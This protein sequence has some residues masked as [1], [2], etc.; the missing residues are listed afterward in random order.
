MTT[1]LLFSVFPYA[2]LAVLAGGL[3][4]RCTS[5][6]SRGVDVEAAEAWTLF[7][8]GRI[9][10]VGFLVLALL[11]LGG[12]MLPRAILSWNTVPL[13]LYVLEGSGFAFGLLALGWWMGVMRRHLRSSKAVVSDFADG[14]FLS[15]TFVGIMSGL[16]TASLYRWGS[17]WGAATL[18]PY[19]SSLLAGA[20]LVS[21]VEQ[22]PLLVQLHVVAAFAL[23]M[24]FPFTRA[25]SLVK[26]AVL[27]VVSLLEA[28]FSAASGGAR[29]WVDRYDPASW[30]WPEEGALDI[31]AP[32]AG[33]H[34][35][36]GDMVVRG[37]RSPATL[38]PQS[39]VRPS[40]V[41]DIGSGYS[42]EEAD[43]E[44]QKTGSDMG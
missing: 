19:G 12:M 10:R 1:D 37:P 6:S 35:V 3:V 44:T 38:P 42:L 14:A 8:G 27:R 43:A 36:S 20:P 28:P 23:M 32:R 15:L 39:G 30:I 18:A 29:A 41:R 4:V 34:D 31:E 5:P 26:V 7:G 22:M 2:A 13:R 25:A 11:H 16:L 33:G 24:V 21:F 17:S 9:W 40:G